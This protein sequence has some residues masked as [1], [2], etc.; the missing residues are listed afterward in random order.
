MDQHCKLILGSSS[1]RR[2]NLLKR[3]GLDFDLTVPQESHDFSESDPGAFVAE[4]VRSKLASVIPPKD[5]AV[6]C[7]DTIVVAQGKVLGKPTDREAAE[8]MLQ[9]LSGQEHCV[10]TAYA[11]K[12]SQVWLKTV[13]T[14]VWM[15]DISASWIKTYLHHASY[16]DKAGG[17]GIQEHGGVFVKRIKGSLTNVMGLPMKEVFE[18]LIQAGVV[19]L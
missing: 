2:K 4:V 7:A 18:T 1:P 17:Y 14:K 10:M 9:V 6:I 5:G 13:Q 15:H 8:Q 16:L 11:I 3:W 19:T 12:S